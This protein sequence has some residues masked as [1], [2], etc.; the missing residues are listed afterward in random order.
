MS[1]YADQAEAVYVDVPL[2]DATSENLADYGVMI[3]EAVHRPGLSIPFY[4]GSVEEGQNLDFEY[5][6]RAVIR[7]ARISHRSPEITWLERHMNMTQIFVGLG[8][9]PFAMVLGKPNHNSGEK[10][11]RLEDVRAF[12]IPAGQGVMIHVGTWHDFP[13]AISD[14]VT[15]MTMNSDEVV[16]A[17]ANAQSADEMDDGDVY[18]IDIQRR[19]GRILR[20]PF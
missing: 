17:L 7:T 13:M 15:V 20:V 4:K 5:T 18:K 6:G 14:P 16:K 10:T 2:L 3:G 1:A 19:T 11:P 9:V 12:R 8:S